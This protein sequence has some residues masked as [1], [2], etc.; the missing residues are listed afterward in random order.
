MK[1]VP[2][3]DTAWRMDHPMGTVAFNYLMSGSE[4]KTPDNFRYILGRQEADFHMPRHRHTFDQIRLPLVGNMNLGEQ[5]ILRE[6]EIGYFPEGQTYGP[7]DDPLGDPKQLQLVLQFGGTSGL[8]VNGI[9][10]GP[11]PQQGDGSGRPRLQQ[12]KFPRPRYRNV[13]IADPKRFNWL[14]VPSAKGLEHKHLGSFTERGV[15]IELLK[16]DSG[17]D[18]TSTDPGARRLFVAL[19]GVGRVEDQEVE[20][21]SALQVDAGEELHITAAQQLELFLIGLPPVPPPSGESEEQFDLVDGTTGIQF[22]DPAKAA[23]E[24][25]R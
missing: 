16:L 5:G 15:W 17:A 8:G 23:A 1:V 21:L 14:P 9:V 25:A 20:R 12:G 10:Q 24:G 11:R 7:Q 2:F 19:S 6:G 4:A 18:W 22:E 3:D 13:I